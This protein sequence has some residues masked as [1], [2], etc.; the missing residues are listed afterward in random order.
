VTSLPDNDAGNAW[1]RWVPPRIGRYELVARLAT[2]GMGEV[3]VARLTGP[4]AFEKRVALKL[5]LPHLCDDPRF[6][7]MFR[8]EARMAARME[9]PN[10]VQIFDQGEAHGRYFLTMTLVRGASLSELLKASQQRGEK[11]PLPVVGAIAVGLCDALA[12]AHGLRTATGAPDP[13]IHRDVSPSNVLVSSAGAVLLTDFGVAKARDNLHHTATAQRIGKYPYMSPEQVAG[14]PVDARADLFSAGITLFEALTGL[15]PFAREGDVATMEAV[16]TAEIPDLRTLRPDV[17]PDI[18]EAISTALTRDREQRPSDIRALKQA[19]LAHPLATAETLGAWVQDLSGSLLDRF[20]PK[21]RMTETT[22]AGTPAGPVARSRA[23][24]LWPGVVAGVLLLGGTVGLWAWTRTPPTEQPPAP[25]WVEAPRTVA[26]EPT[27]P[28]PSVPKPV[29]STPAPTRAPSR[30]RVAPTPKGLTV[31]YLTANAK[32]WAAVF[33]G[34]QELD[35]TPMSRYPLPVGEHVLIFRN[36]DL[37]TEARRT[38]RITKGS[39]VTLEV[40]LER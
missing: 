35:R 22:S 36:P 7:Q 30:K 1:R 34:N 31:G 4:G 19:F 21:V 39:I 32:P 6:V 40:N 23:R 2:G 5:L 13:I 37:G 28:E 27:V 25:A 16:R 17:P 33:L 29:V 15:S 38:V 9:H 18:A 10:I 12:H 14:T 3:F 20:D 24:L 8:D 26:P 11:I